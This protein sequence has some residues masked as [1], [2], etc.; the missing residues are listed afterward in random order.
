M[1]IEPVTLEAE[2]IRLE[3]LSRE[4]HL[5]ELRE[6]GASP[7][8]F[9]WFGDDYSTREGMEAFVEGALDAHEEG[10]S[11]P[12]ATVHRETGETI[13][14][15][16]FCTIRPEGRSVE[17]GWTWLTP[18]HQRTPANTEAKYLML[19]HAFEE[20][21]C[22]RVEFKT[23]AGNERSRAALGRIGATMEG[24]LRKRMLIH[25]KPTDCAYFSITDREWPAVKESLEAK[26]DRPMP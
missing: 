20:W 7:S 22:A 21:S 12:F 11:L 18:D 25:G 5:T 26:L 16:R 9:E 6:A 1:N 13:G 8:L 17:I 4:N 3:P 10:E 2:Y 23:A 14:S 19:R 24:I 15:T